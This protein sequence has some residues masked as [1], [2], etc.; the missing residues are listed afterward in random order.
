MSF[1]VRD[2]VSRVH[3]TIVMSTFIHP[4]NLQPVLTV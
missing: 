3:D 4:R 1:R 2:R